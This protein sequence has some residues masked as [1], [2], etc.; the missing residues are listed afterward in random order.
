MG[1]V[2]AAGSGESGTYSGSAYFFRGLSDCN[3]NGTL[4]I[5]EM[6]ADPS[7]DMNGNGILDECELGDMNCDGSVDF[8]DIDPFILA[9]GGAVYLHGR[10]GAAGTITGFAD[11]QPVTLAHLE[12]GVV[13]GVHVQLHDEV[14]C[15]QVLVSM[16]DRE[17]RIQLAAIE[18]DLERLRAEVAAAQARLP[19]ENA[20]VQADVDDLVRRFAVDRENARIEYLSQLVVDAHDRILLPGRMVE[21]ETMRDLYAQGS[22][23]VLEL[24][25]V[26]TEVDALQ[27]SIA[28]RAEVLN[29]LNEAFQ[30]ADQRWARFAGHEEVG[31]AFE[32]VLT[33]LRLA[34]DVR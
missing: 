15:G 1:V 12:M 11:D 28:Q 26:Q 33:P 21:Y 14:A 7:L 4:D 34:V 10:I 9:I 3:T 32:P 22:A 30:D 29:R 2:G 17:E 20:R 18:K 19:A 16:D 8:F 27:A 23:A 6:T 24:N 25:E 31:T 5:C 13:R